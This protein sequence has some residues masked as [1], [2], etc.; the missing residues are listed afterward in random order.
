M[1][2]AES[3]GA[4]SARGISVT[5]TG[6]AGLT[7]DMRCSWWR[8]RAP[9][10]IPLWLAM[11]EPSRSFALSPRPPSPG[12]SRGGV[13]WSRAP[14]PSSVPQLSPAVPGGGGGASVVP[15][16]VAV[17]VLTPCSPLPFSHRLITQRQPSWTRFVTHL[18]VFFL[19][20]ERRPV[21]HVAFIPVGCTGLVDAARIRRRAFTRPS[22][23]LCLLL[24]DSPL[25]MP[26]SR[27]SGAT[28]PV[29][30]FRTVRF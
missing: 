18:W 30:C 8:G 13:S 29:L 19:G 22:Q 16:S 23:L 17:C 27:H 14:P 4:A 12:H 10:A 2:A 5:P 26:T 21:S 9:P 28:I 6:V 3:Q 20:G 24:S 7:W 1:P 11:A 15:T 25:L